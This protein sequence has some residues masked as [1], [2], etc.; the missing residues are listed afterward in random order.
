MS[1]CCF[2]EGVLFCCVL[3]KCGC[4]DE[5]AGEIFVLVYFSRFSF[6]HVCVMMRL[7]YCI[8]FVSSVYTL[9]RVCLFQDMIFFC[10]VFLG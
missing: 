1:V 4:L 3:L 8:V 7:C 10:A 9:Y 6:A 5:I 2:D